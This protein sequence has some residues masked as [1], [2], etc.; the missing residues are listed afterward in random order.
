LWSEEDQVIIQR[1]C[2]IIREVVVHNPFQLFRQSC[3]KKASKYPSQFFIFDQNTNAFISKIGKQFS[4]FFLMDLSENFSNF[5]YEDENG[6]SLSN[7]WMMGERKEM[8]YGFLRSL[9]FEDEFL[10]EED[11]MM[12]SK[13]QVSALGIGK[14]FEVFE[15]SKITSSSFRTNS[16]Y[17][18]SLEDIK[19]IVSSHE[20]KESSFLNNIFSSL[21]SSL[22]DDAVKMRCFDISTFSNSIPLTHF[23]SI[24]SIDF[25]PHQFLFSIPQE[26]FQQEEEMIQNKNEELNHFLIQMVIK[27]QHFIMSSFQ[28][29][30]SKIYCKSFIHLSFLLPYQFQLLSHDTRRNMF[31]IFH[32]FIELFKDFF[33]FSFHFAF[34]IFLSFLYW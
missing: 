25:S 3:D 18:S 8:G 4:D 24:L 22:F 12:E 2:K 15:F 6:S 9:L 14:G 20:H 16:T 27:F 33:C 17:E 26:L 7:V 5:K 32:E 28:M 13:S 23:N 10:D 21:S 19:R 11:E 29:I 31:S 30:P 34:F 1:G